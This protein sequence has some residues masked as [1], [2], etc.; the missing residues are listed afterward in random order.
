M[1]SYIHAFTLALALVVSGSA[2]AEKRLN[3][4]TAAQFSSVQAFHHDTV[5][6]FNKVDLEGSPSTINSNDFVLPNA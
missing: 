1:N 4:R 5:K 6:R 3:G 2:S